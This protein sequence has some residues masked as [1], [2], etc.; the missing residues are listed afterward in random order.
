ML[1]ELLVAQNQWLLFC[2]RFSY[3]TL[4][5]YTF[6][7]IIIFFVFGPERWCR[8]FFS[9][10]FLSIDNV[11]YESVYFRPAVIKV[12]VDW[13]LFLSFNFGLALAADMF[14]LEVALDHHHKLTVDHPDLVHVLLATQTL[15]DASIQSETLAADECLTLVALLDGHDWNTLT[16]HAL[17]DLQGF[18][19]FNHFRFVNVY[20]LTFLSLSDQLRDV[21]FNAILI[22]LVAC[23]FKLFVL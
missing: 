5:I 4:V 18:L 17:K 19:A 16:L 10:Y 21:L 22:D 1:Q 23:F 11:F 9:R 3:L 6:F 14:E 7:F 8:L 13:L 12:S 2:L 20:L 15:L